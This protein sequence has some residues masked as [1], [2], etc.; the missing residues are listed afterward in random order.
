M[1]ALLD[2]TSCF[3]FLSSSNTHAKI[4]SDVPRRYYQQIGDLLQHFQP[5]IDGI[6]SDDMIPSDQLST[7]FQQLT[8]LINQALEQIQN[9]NHMSSKLYFVL[10]IEPLTTKL[11]TSMLAIGKSVE[12]TDHI[13]VSIWFD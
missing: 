8:S 3:R 13:K 7:L 4:N 10:Q 6:I 1:K 11:Q 5:I 12:A 2:S 9:W